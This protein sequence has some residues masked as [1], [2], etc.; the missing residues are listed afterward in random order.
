[1][2]MIFFFCVHIASDKTFTKFHTIP[3]KQKMF[4]SKMTENHQSNFP[5][6]YICVWGVLN[7]TDPKLL[8]DKVYWKHATALRLTCR[9]RRTMSAMNDLFVFQTAGISLVVCLLKSTTVPPWP[10]ESL[11]VWKQS[12]FLH[13]WPPS[14]N[15][16]RQH[17]LLG[18]KAH[19]PVHGWSLVRNTNYD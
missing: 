17:S 9:S 19:S 18:N 11:A 13:P 10:S 4:Q 12:H 5:K 14:D 1:M 7:F 3:M 6:H 16:W 15:P 2:S 8:N